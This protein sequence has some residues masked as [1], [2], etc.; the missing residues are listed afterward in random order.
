VQAKKEQKK[1][2]REKLQRI[3][4]MCIA[5]ENHT[6]DPFLLDVDDVISVVKEYFPQWKEA[7]DLNLDSEAIHHLAS[8]IKLQSE[9]VK[10]RSTSLYTDPFLLEE[11]IMQ[12]GKEEMLSVFLG[13]WHPVVELE[14]LS[15]HS[16]AEAIRYWEELLPLKERWPELAVPEV[17]IG[18]TSRDELIKEQVLGDKF[19]SEQL[20]SYWQELKEKVEA[21]GADGKMRYWD[22]V[23]ADT[24]EETVKRAFL[25]SFLISYGYATL[26]IHPLEEEVFIKPFEKPETKIQTQQSISIPLAVTYD[27]WQKWKR[28]E[29]D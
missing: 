8:V 16:L 17:A 13:A 5:I 11:K 20:E 2:G 6:V 14:Q 4:D 10:H 19:F 1:F 26:E 12:A 3:I 28:G 25:A 24:Y 7:A 27:D 9:W 23:G 18:L 29:L 21:K 15:L 22:F